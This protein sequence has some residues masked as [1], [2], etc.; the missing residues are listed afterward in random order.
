M[1][2]PARLA[3]GSAASCAMTKPPAVGRRW[4]RA[5]ENVPDLGSCVSLV[6]PGEEQ[7]AVLKL[8]GTAASFNW[9]AAETAIRKSLKIA[10]G[11]ASG[12]GWSWSCASEFQACFRHSLGPFPKVGS[13]TALGMAR[14]GN[15]DGPIGHPA[16]P[17][18]ASAAAAAAGRR[19]A[20][21]DQVVVHGEERQ[22]HAVGGADLVE[23]VAQV[24]LDRVLAEHELLGDF[25]VGVPRHDR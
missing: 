14:S 20:A 13:G 8:G 19:S 6:H 25:P 22:L 23:D 16:W 10:C 11:G 1:L 15:A 2:S 24:V 3:A 4:R 18:R 17:Y 9:S 7:V 21:I 5:I 12:P